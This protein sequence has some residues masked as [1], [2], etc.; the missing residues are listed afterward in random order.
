MGVGELAHALAGP[1]E[2]TDHLCA[3]NVGLLST[4]GYFAYT[5]RDQPWDRRVVGSAVA[6]TLALFGAEG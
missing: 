1:H 6:G 2:L 3:V 5:R 4:I